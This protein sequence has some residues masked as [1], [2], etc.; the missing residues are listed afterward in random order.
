MMEDVWRKLLKGNAGTCGE[1]GCD[2]QYTHSG[3][4]VCPKCGREQLDDFGKVKRYLETQGAATA[5][6]ISNATGVELAIIKELLDAGRITM[7]HTEGRCS[8]CGAGIARGQFCEA[9]VNEIAFGIKREFREGARRE[10]DYKAVGKMR[11]LYQ[12]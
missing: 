5:L 2:T 7:P 9:C 1:C 4:Y 8:R 6:E 11:F 3:I 10:K 12:K